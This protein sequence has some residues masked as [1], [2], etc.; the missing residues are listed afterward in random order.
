MPTT[1]SVI[2]SAEARH[3]AER[4]TVRIVIAIEGGD[5]R[6]V[7][8]AGARRHAELISGVRALH[9]ETA[10]PV[11]WFSSE[12]LRVSAERPWN[13]EGRQLPLVYRSASSV[14]V[15]FD[16]F[17]RLSEWVT[18]SIQLD[19]VAVAG[20]IWT[21]TDQRRLEMTA[22][23]EHE[24]VRDAVAKA[25]RYA[26]SLGLG[27]LHPIAVSDPG[28]LDGAVPPPEQGI[29]PARMMSA[30]RGPATIEFAPEEIV[31]AATVHA[32][33]SAS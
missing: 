21:L 24:A 15:E 30:G 23:V 27:A 9:D 7:T 3:P 10:G 22:G 16:D 4:G 28:L 26:A 19:G 13:S 25:E 29:G 20:I 8:D 18:E 11:T 12:Q 6:T 5:R 31:V 17:T 2:G 32:R 1:I 33:F 14:S